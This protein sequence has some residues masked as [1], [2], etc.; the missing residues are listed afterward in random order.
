M[1]SAVT[2]VSADS[3]IA[4]KQQ[5]IQIAEGFVLSACLHVAVKLNVAAYL[6]DGPCPVETLAA[7]TSSNA[8]A[9]YRVLRALISI[10]VFSE[11][12]PRTIALSPRAELL[13]GDVSE[14]IRDLVLW[15]SNPFVMQVTSDLLYSVETGKPAIEHLFGK[16]A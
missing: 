11:P 16:P 14:N 15:V 4:L 7:K 8:D 3:T 1:A 6:A 5:L 2:D 12:Q 9:L 13:R 10:S